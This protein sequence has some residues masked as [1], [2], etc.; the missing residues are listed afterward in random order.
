[1]A[2]PHKTRTPRPD[3]KPQRRGS[4]ASFGFGAVFMLG[5]LVAT[6]QTGGSSLRSMLHE[7]REA[8]NEYRVQC[9]ASLERA[10]GALRRAETIL[11]AR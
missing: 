10:V 3:E 2:P 8:H 11:E 7:Q 6:G 1:M 4:W 5:L 9:E